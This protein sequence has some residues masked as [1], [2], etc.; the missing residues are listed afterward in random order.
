MFIRSGAQENLME[1]VEDLNICWHTAREQSGE[2][3]LV[4]L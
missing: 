4:I 2:K 3:G 1:I